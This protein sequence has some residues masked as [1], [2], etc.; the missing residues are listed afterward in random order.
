MNGGAVRQVNRIGLGLGAVLLAALLWAVADYGWRKAGLLGLGTLL[1]ITLYHASFG[2]SGAYRRFIVERDMSGVAAQLVML[3]IAIVL[4]APFLAEGEIAGRRVV[5]AV[6]PVGVGMAFGAFLFGVGM[7]LAGGCASGTLFVAGS[8]NGR[9]VVVLVMFCIGAFIG[10]L[11]LGWWNDLPRTRAISL[12]KE[13][14]WPTAVAVQLGVLAAIYLA[15]RSIGGRVDRR[16]WSADLDPRRW[17]QGPWPLIVGGVLLALLSFAVL[18]VAGH[19]W[20]VTWG[21]TLWGAKAAVQVGWD[22]T[23]S[24]FWQGRFQSGALARP[25]L[26]DTVSIMNIGILLGAMIAASLGGRFGLRLNLSGRDVITAMIGGLMLGYGARLAYGCNIGAFFS[27]VASSSL[28]GWVWI[29]AAAVGNVL[30]AR[31]TALRR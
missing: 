27:G 31:L 24:A 26:D 1:G 15:L 28:H 29:I 18:W 17:W 12:G 25:I 13:W 4:F 22:P 14:G 2:F 21:Y 7:Q 5:G 16:F 23:T 11:H 30:G 8:G 6:A 9:M 20:S 19:P 3:A 10:S